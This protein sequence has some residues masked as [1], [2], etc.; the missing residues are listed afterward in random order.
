MASRARKLAVNKG[1]DIREISMVFPEYR[2]DSPS[3]IRITILL[4]TK[5][6]P[7]SPLRSSM[8]AIE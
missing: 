4:C 8:P 2:P 1:I 5:A 3:A 7:E 6:S